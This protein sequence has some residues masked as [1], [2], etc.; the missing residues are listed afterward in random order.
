MNDLNHRSW[1]LVLMSPHSLERQVS[2]HVKDINQFLSTG[3]E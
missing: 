2:S 1:V 3:S